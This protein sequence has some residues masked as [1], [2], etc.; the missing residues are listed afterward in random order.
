MN[1]VEK[2]NVTLQKLVNQHDF[3]K[4][5]ELMKNKVLNHPEI[6]AFL[7]G[8]QQ[9]IT[10]QMIDRSLMKLHEYTTQNRDCDH[11]ESLEK[12]PN[13]LKGY[14]PKLVIR[15]NVIDLQYERCPRKIVY[16]E[17]RK[18]EQLIQSIYVPKE[19]LSASF[20]D[21]EVDAGRLK[22]IELAE[23]FV[24]S[25]QVGQKQKGL[26]LYGDFGVGKTYL[27]GAI[28]N[29]LAKKQISSLIV[30]VPEF[31]REMKSAIG[32]QTLDK[33]LETIKN[34]QVLMLDDIGAESMSAWVRDD[35]L[36][37]IL[38]FRM[39]DNLPTF[40]TSNKDFEG[41]EDHLT[42]SRGEEEKLKAARIMERIKYL[43]I[44]VPLGG[45]NRRN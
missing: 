42:Y 45:K 7:R 13:M 8:N 32:D 29:E 40:F 17:R 41:L 33:K 2:I 30:Y 16:D 4:R 22:A 11:C 12:C 34:A 44:P 5:Y 15:G 24:S 1:G 23:D 9:Q 3:K 38:Q 21:I 39:L 19:I 14:Q 10:A 18:Q 43:A 25:F 36:G 6:Q 31:L 26:Y 35:I 27:L 20:A 37:T 28:A